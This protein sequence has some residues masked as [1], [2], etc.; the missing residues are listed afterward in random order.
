MKIYYHTRCMLSRFLRDED[1]P[2]ATEYAI[3]LAMLIIGAMA[4]ISGIGSRMMGLYTSIN[5]AI[6]S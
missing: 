4:A 1:G 3:L 5:S 6:P 2:T